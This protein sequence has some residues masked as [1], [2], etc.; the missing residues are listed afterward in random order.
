MDKKSFKK[1]A[2]KNLKTWFNK[3]V[4]Q[5]KFF[6]RSSKIVYKKKK[7]KKKQTQIIKGTHQPWP[8]KFK[9]V[10]YSAIIYKIWDKKH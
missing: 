6:K 10:T 3:I 9:K 7:R 8:K 4:T 2:L 5:T 1:T